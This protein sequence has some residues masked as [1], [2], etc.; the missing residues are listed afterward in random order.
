M[1][2]LRTLACSQHDGMRLIDLVRMTGLNQPT[3]H[4]TLRALIEEGMVNQNLLTRRYL[5]GEEISTL[6]LARSKTVGLETI[7]NPHLNELARQTG[8]TVFLSIRNR[9]DSI[10]ISRIT[11]HHPIQVLSIDIGV[12]RPLGVGVSGIAL[13]SCLTNQESNSIIDQNHHRFHL[14]NEDSKLI[15]TKVIDARRLGYAYAS[16]GLMQG[17]SAVSMPI[18]NSSGTALGAITISTMAARLENKRLETA[19][20]LMKEQA[21]LITKRYFIK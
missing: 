21:D 14:L 13:L 4:R 10:C 18:K 11:G 16:Q 5:I 1:K 7:I 8:D 19:I 20:S 3:V 2:I 6:A 9:L 12:R 17:T 15:H